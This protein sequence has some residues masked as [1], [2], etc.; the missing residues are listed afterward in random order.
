LKQSKL[1][2]GLIKGLSVDYLP[3]IKK[4][5]NSKDKIVETY[6]K[7]TVKTIHLMD[8]K[9]FL[10]FSSL[11]VFSV[12]SEHLGGNLVCAD[13]NDPTFIFKRFEIDF[14]KSEIVRQ[15]DF[16]SGWNFFKMQNHL[17][18][19]YRPV[20]SNM[21]LLGR[22]FSFS[23]KMYYEV[24][25]TDVN[26]KVKNRFN[27]PLTTDAENEMKYD[28]GC[29]IPEFDT[30]YFYILRN[31]EPH[32]ESEISGR[33][34]NSSN[35]SKQHLGFELIK[36]KL[37]NGEIVWS[38]FVDYI[39]EKKY[40]FSGF[41]GNRIYMQGDYY[42]EFPIEVI[43]RFNKIIVRKWAPGSSSSNDR[44]I[45]MFDTSGNIILNKVMTESKKE[46]KKN[47]MTEFQDED[48]K[49][50]SFYEGWKK[51]KTEGKISIDNIPYFNPDNFYLVGYDE[52][53][54]KCYIY[55]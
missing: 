4:F 10:E 48:I 25:C 16:N 18:Y 15:P 6:S 42:P 9:V 30:S 3:F 2:A 52:K 26:G 14:P 34:N 50:I 7:F 20:V 37:N 12:E 11:P 13:I 40:G 47:Y 23:G 19:F 24:I 8:D 46:M 53:L 51:M 17:L 54:R 31:F 36:C 41:C 44:M 43:C 55:K 32:P 1:S 21:P 38:K 45:T 29:Y 49:D 22:T 5:A 28:A 33:K 27:I 35:K 39:D